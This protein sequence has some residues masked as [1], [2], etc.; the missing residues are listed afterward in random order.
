MLKIPGKEIS[1]ST[2]LKETLPPGR[3]NRQEVALNMENKLFLIS[4]CQENGL[5]FFW[6]KKI[7]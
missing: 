7:F 2:L 4:P 6:G 1:Q 5:A 3:K